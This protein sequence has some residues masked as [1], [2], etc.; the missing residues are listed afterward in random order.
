ME[1]CRQVF[2]LLWFHLG[3]YAHL[4]GRGD[5]REEQPPALLPCAALPCTALLTVLQV[6]QPLPW[7]CGAACVPKAV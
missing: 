1:S 3:M 6:C 2:V 7:P 4:Q 5:A